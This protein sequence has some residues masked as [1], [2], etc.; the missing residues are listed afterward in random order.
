MEILDTALGTELLPQE[1]VLA[2]WVAWASRA[3]DRPWDWRRGL[4]TGNHG[5]GARTTRK[6][7]SEITG[8]TPVPHVWNWRAGLRPRWL[9]SCP[10]NYKKLPYV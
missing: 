7:H 1:G 5:R 8:G 10:L 6:C 9:L 2:I 4:E 3:G